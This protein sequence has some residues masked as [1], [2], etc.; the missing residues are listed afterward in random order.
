MELY[1]A[2]HILI[3]KKFSKLIDELS[4]KKP[5]NLYEIMFIYCS[6][7]INPINANFDFFN[8]FEKSDFSILKIRL[9]YIKD[10]EVYINVIEKT[11]K[12]YL[13][14]LASKLMKIIF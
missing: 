13:T 1:F 5:E 12:M 8:K 9:S 6:H 7:F 10:L 11:K 4:N 14:N 3:V 2:T